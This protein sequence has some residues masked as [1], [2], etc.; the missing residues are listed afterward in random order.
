MGLYRPLG[1]DLGYFWNGLR[2]EQDYCCG[3]AEPGLHA[4]NYTDQYYTIS[5]GYTSKICPGVKSGVFLP[6]K[7]EDKLESVYF[8]LDD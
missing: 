1:F 7:F 6:D 5:T 3:Y 8:I 2:E 4:W